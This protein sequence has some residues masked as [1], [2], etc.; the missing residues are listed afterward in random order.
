MATDSLPVED[1]ARLLSGKRVV[2]LTGAG[3]STE[4]GIPDYRGPATRHVPRNPVQHR[5]FVRDPAVRRR[6]WARAFVGWERFRGARPNRGHDTLAA[7][8]RCGAVSGIV[9]Q[10]V[11]RLHQAAGSRDVIELHGALA[12][13]RCLGCGAIEAREDVQHRLTVLNPELSA[14]HA[15][16]A[17]DGDADLARELYEGFRP[18]ECLACG[19]T[20][21]P[22]VVFFGGTV[23]KDVVDAA[24]ARV[25]QAEVLLVLGTSLTVFSGFRFV[26][27]ARELGIA[28]GLVNLGETR[29][30]PFATVRVD[31]PLGEVLPALGERLLSRSRIRG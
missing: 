22:N 9:T 4:S 23:P 11:D 26:R 1:L 5:D 30:D 29:G 6:Y 20:L 27:R 10:N 21:M 24:F 19:G 18:A 3:I 25:E 31:A 13:V 8:E 28:I 2:A 15:T 17:P 16:M 7:L 12:E 14:S